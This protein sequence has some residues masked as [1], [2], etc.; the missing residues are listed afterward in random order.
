[1]ASGLFH[2]LDD[3]A[4]NSNLLSQFQSSNDE[5]DKIMKSYDLSDP[6]SAA[7]RGSNADAVSKMLNGELNNTFGDPAGPYNC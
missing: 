6:Q 5:A 7:I 1:M 2:L 3:L 4:R